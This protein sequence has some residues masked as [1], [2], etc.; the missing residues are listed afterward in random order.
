MNT[1]SAALNDYLSALLHLLA[2]CFECSQTL[3]EIK[4]GLLLTQVDS[5]MVTPVS[6]LLQSHVK[7]LHTTLGLLHNNTLSHLFLT[8]YQDSIVLKCLDNT[9]VSRMLLYLP[10][11]I[12]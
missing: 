7:L 5:K 11:R 6:Q 1:V 9:S 4:L 2:E 3:F 8:Y 10:A 12:Q